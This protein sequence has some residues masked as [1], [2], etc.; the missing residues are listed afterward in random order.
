MH[1]VPQ[2]ILFGRFV[3]KSGKSHQ[4][5]SSF[6]HQAG[7]ELGITVTNQHSHHPFTSITIQLTSINIHQHQLPFLITDF[8]QG[9]PCIPSS[10]SHWRRPRSRRHGVPGWW[11]T[12]RRPR[13]TRSSPG[14]SDPSLRET[15]TPL[16]DE[17]GV[18]YWNI[19]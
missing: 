2:D 13:A 6:L 16:S 4:P 11:R 7:T 12:S 19:L 18:E 14:C 17:I 5:L 10:C 9:S 8:I 15:L 3:G 1:H